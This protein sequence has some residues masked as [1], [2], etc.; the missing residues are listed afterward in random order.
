MFAAIKRWLDTP[1]QYASFWCSSV[2][3]RPRANKIKNTPHPSATIRPTV[4]AATISPS[5]GG[6]AV[7]VPRTTPQTKI[8][9][10]PKPRASITAQPVLLWEQRKWTP[11]GNNLHGYFRVKGIGAVK[12]EIHNYRSRE[13]HFFVINPPEIY[14]HR[15][16]FHPK[17]NGRWWIHFNRLPGVDA[18]I[19]AVEAIMADALRRR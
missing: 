2:A 4:S 8:N 15:E 5:R 12:G 1:P 18:G 10:A 16:C 17:G 19:F 7:V 6:G 3:T 9:P 11:T 14:S 13:P